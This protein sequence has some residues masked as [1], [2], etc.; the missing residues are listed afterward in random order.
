LALRAAAFGN[1][2]RPVLRHLAVP[3]TVLALA[4]CGGG[5]AASKAGGPSGPVTLRIAADDIVDTRVNDYVRDFAARVNKL[6]GGDIRI[7][8]KVD[9]V[10]ASGDYNLVLARSV[11]SGKFEMGMVPSEVWDLL[12]VTSLRALTA[13]FLITDQA[14][15]A[16]V[17]SGELGKRMLAGLDRADVVGLA[18][19]PGPLVHPFGYDRPLLEV[20]DYRGKVLFARQSQTMEA[21]LRALGARS[22]RGH[23]PD[24]D[25]EDGIA[26]PFEWAPEATGTGN[27]TLYPVLDALVIGDRAYARLDTHQRE[28]LRQAA[29]EARAL[30]IKTFPNEAAAARE[31]CTSD[32]GSTRA[33][34]LASAPQVA[35][36]EA[37]VAPVYTA[38]ERDPFTRSAIA[39]IRARKLE[40]PQR[41]T[42]SCPGERPVAPVRGKAS[43]TLDGVYRFELTDT[44]MRAE[45]V[46]PGLIT[47][48]RGVYT[49]TLSGGKYC[50]ELKQPKRT[51][52]NPNYTPGACGIY[53]LDGDRMGMSLPTGAPATLRWHKTANGDLRF[54]VVSSGSWG[55]ALANAIV[56]DPWKRI[57]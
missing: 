39:R 3:A 24:R 47:E 22:V 52:P 38:L 6:S 43:A 49:Y 16:D 51:S 40:L 32:P 12:G 18:L 55:P 1:E 10:M 35:A 15:L 31:F 41:P 54:A 46:D 14:L 36:L 34:V 19:F 20:G 42:P 30:A 5:G 57:G 25:L 2:M 23:M 7:E 28:I 8:L 4:G 56:A 37:A 33:V 53:R 50:Y 45:L 48:T 17:I 26:Q 9:A 29:T 27:V 11:A 21:M 13:P 44:K